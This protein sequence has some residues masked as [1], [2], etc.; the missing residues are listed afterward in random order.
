VESKLLVALTGCV[1]HSSLWS[2]E[3]NDTQGESYLHPELCISLSKICH[4]DTGK[5]T[6]E[7]PLIRRRELEN[8][9]TAACLRNTHE[10]SIGRE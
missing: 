10:A 8:V 5:Y 7:V 1:L 6:Y 3:L 4:E 2:L 9:H